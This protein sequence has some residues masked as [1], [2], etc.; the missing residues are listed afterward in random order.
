MTAVDLSGVLI[1]VVTPFQPD[2]GDP[3]LDAFRSNL[4][5]WL[6]EPIRGLVVGGSTG[7]AVF[8]DR[9][10]RRSLV[11]AAREVTP[12]DRLLVAGTGAESTRAT[13]ALTADAAEAGAD[14]VLVQ[15]PAY[16][17]GAMTPGVLRNHYH[18][19]AEAS[20]VPVILYQ[21]PLRFSTI[22]FS[23][24]LV[25]ELSKY[26]NIVGIKDSRGDL[27]ALGELVTASRGGFQVLVGNGAKL[28]ASLEVG[29]VG[30]ILG[31]ANLVAGWSAEIHEAFA[32]GDHPRAGQ[33]PGTGRAAAQRHRVPLGRARGEVGPG[34]PGL[35]G[36]RPPPPP[37]PPGRG[38]PGRGAGSAGPG[39]AGVGGGPPFLDPHPPQR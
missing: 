30:G 19:V 13:V 5:R 23:S 32:A 34:H 1:P 38:R 21:V 36:R 9:E 6:Q 37:S 20:P 26:P 25:G 24:G 31:V 12:D 17:K 35:P 28:Y 7:E 11:A 27:A 22:E 33:D 39:G 2:D 15:P 4:E 8:L 29:A 3:D 18:A 10:E 16:Y 14:A